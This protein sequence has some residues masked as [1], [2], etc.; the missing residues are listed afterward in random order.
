NVGWH[1]D[2]GSP[3]TYVDGIRS[4]FS[5]KV[6]YF[7]TDLLEPDMGQLMVVPG[8]HRFRDGL[9]YRPGSDQPEGALQLKVRAGDAV[10]FQNP[11]YH[12]SAPNRSQ[13]TRIVLYYGYSYRWLK[14]IDYEKMPEELM[15]SATPVQRQLLGARSSH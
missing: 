15:A 7:L 4:M 12:G 6:G 11:L 5:L 8:S 14:P 3:G 9:K 2:G 13:Q 10:L 1:Q